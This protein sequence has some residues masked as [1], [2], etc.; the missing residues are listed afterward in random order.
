LLWAAAF[1]FGPTAE[2]VG[3]G[4]DD[5]ANWL[6]DLVTGWTLLATGLASRVRR[7]ESRFGLLLAGTSVA[8][9]A[10]TAWSALAALHRAP[11]AQ[12]IFAFPSGRLASTVVRV[13]VGALYVTWPLGRSEGATIGFAML[14]VAIPLAGRHLAIGV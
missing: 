13:V 8:W 6:P 11:L 1:G 4:F 14:L 9:F 5:S 7:P 2:W 10:G 12:A 3:F